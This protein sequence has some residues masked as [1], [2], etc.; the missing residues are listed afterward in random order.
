MRYDRL[1]HSLAWNASSRNIETEAATG[2]HV[3]GG[4]YSDGTITFSGTAGFSNFNVTDITGDGG[5][6]GGS[7]NEIQYNLLRK[8]FLLLL[9]L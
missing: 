3:T 5:N 6:P 1:F 8:Y 7:A 2:P 9:F 4:S